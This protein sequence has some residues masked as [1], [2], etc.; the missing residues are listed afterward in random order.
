VPP[1][2]LFQET[3][4]A[5]SGTAEEAEL[6]DVDRNEDASSAS[7]TFGKIQR[8]RQAWE[9]KRRQFEFMTFGIRNSKEWLNH[10][11]ATIGI[12]IFL[13]SAQA[14]FLGGPIAMILAY[15]LIGSVAYA[16]T[17]NLS[18]LIRLIR[19]CPLEKWY[20]SFQF[21]ALFS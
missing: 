15:I 9:L 17:V 10:L 4:F 19:R 8:R 11:G 18:H 6:D 14:L 2:S 13:R 7:S 5:M 12:G 16:I 20:L 3:E 1:L 21:Q